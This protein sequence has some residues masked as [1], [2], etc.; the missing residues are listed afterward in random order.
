MQKSKFK[1]TY[2]IVII[3]L[4]GIL[5]GCSAFSSTKLATT[6]YSSSTLENLKQGR[7]YASA[8]RYELAREH[9]LLALASSEGSGATNLIT[10]ELQAVDLMIK[11]QR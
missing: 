1:Y 8:G 11:T 2:I 6:P 3:L 4:L 5:S 7:E 10:Q 9:Y